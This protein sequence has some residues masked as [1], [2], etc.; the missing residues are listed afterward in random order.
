M[1]IHKGTPGFWIGLLNIGILVFICYMP[2]YRLYGIALSF[3]LMGF[4]FWK[5]RI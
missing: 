3:L 2:D 5:T 4:Y 1:I